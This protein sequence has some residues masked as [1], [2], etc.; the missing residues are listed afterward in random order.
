MSQGRSEE[1]LT[2]IPRVKIVPLIP[3]LQ[4]IIWERSKTRLIPLGGS[5]REG[6]EKARARVEE[7]GARVRRVD[8]RQSE[9]AM[10]R[11]RG[12]KRGREGIA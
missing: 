7:D 5:E 2:S 12:K 1:E 8:E 4:R 11:R 6:E 10:A 3:P 9:R